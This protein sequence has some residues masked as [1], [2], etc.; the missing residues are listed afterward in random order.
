VWFTTADAIADWY[1]DNSYDSHL[2][3]AVDAAG[4]AGR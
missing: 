3:F 1:L 2:Q 4:G